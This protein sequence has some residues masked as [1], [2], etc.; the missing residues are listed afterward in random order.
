M[1]EPIDSTLDIGKVVYSKQQ[2]MLRLKFKPDL[3]ISGTKRE[4]PK[5]FS[6]YMIGIKSVQ[7]PTKKPISAIDYINQKVEIKKGTQYCD[8]DVI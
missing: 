2:N 5:E 7:L 1:P 3:D 4:F 6:N 8:K